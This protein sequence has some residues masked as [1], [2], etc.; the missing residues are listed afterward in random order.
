MDNMKNFLPDDEVN[1][2]EIFT[3][4]KR[5]VGLIYPVFILFIIIGGMTY[6]DNLGFIQANKVKPL[7]TIPP[8]F[9]DIKQANG[10]VQPGVEIAAISI[11][12]EQVIAKGKETFTTVCA[13]CH[14]NEGKGDGPAGVALNPKPRN[15]LIGDGWKN[16][17]KISELFKTLQE[18]I[19]GSAMVAYEYLSISDRM[20][21]IHYIRSLSPDYPNDTPDDLKK[22]DETYSLSLG[23]STPNQIPVEKAI[24][25][26]STENKSQV[27]D[28]DAIIKKIKGSKDLPGAKI[29]CKVAS[30]KQKALYTLFKP[31]VLDDIDKFRNS[32]TASS[33]LN[34]FKPSVL[35]IRNEDLIVF[36]D[37]IKNISSI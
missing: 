36:Y 15:F 11:S 35:M 22:L 20:A 34:G 2:K 8:A 9:Q 26:I 28:V 10:V 6:I 23:K 17:R 33:P 29:F 3:N 14:G 1:F 21:L 27:T 18:G 16:G 12:N 5:W 7:D 30:D 24:S 4:P 19:T 32:I 31:G 25:L 37:F 13:S